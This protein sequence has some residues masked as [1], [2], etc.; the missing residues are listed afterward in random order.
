MSSVASGFLHPVP[1]GAVQRGKVQIYDYADF[2]IKPCQF[3]IGTVQRK[4]KRNVA[5]DLASVNSL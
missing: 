3:L 2:G 1:P 5:V 4:Q